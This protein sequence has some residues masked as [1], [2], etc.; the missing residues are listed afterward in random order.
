M[1]QDIYKLLISS[2]YKPLPS[3]KSNSI[4]LGIHRSFDDGDN[5][6]IEIYKEKECYALLLFG[7]G[8]MNGYFPTSIDVFDFDDLELLEK[9]L[10]Q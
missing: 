9:K 1:I 2:G 7:D 5:K 8:F 3:H 6:Y 4:R 10:N